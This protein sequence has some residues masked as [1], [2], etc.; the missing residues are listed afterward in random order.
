MK[1]P[2]LSWRRLRIPV[3]IALIA[4]VAITN[5][6]FI[7]AQTQGPSVAKAPNQIGLPTTPEPAASRDAPATDEEVSTPSSKILGDLFAVRTWE[8]PPPP[9]P[10]PTPPLPPQAPPLPF[11]FVGRINEPDKGDVFL[12]AF[13]DSVLSVV[14]GDTI[15]ERYRLEKYEGGQL[16][17]L[18]RPLNIRQTLNVGSSL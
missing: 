11:K 15:D 8:P 9:L 5:H 3:S 18:Y 10:P 13:T 16:H 6:D 12:L 17:F 2:K 1:R 7:A 14:V 4:L